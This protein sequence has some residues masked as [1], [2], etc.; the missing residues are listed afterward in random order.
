MDGFL[1]DNKQSAVKWSIRY[2]SEPKDQEVNQV[3]LDYTFNF[4]IGFK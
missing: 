1:I 2:L 4:Y 3:V